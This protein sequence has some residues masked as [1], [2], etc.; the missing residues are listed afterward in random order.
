[1]KGW[2]LAG[3]S[4]QSH[5]ALDEGLT[6][7]GLILPVI[8][9]GLIDQ[10]AQV[11]ATLPFLLPLVPGESPPS[12]SGMSCARWKA[13]ETSLSHPTPLPGK[14]WVRRGWRPCPRP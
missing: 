6:H 10:G 9:K 14:G 2:E 3:P 12:A 1:M 4:A 5:G 8:S 7:S 13:A 11:A